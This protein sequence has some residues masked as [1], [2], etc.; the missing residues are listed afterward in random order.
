MPKNDIYQLKVTLRNSKPPIWRRI[1]VPGNIG[2]DKLHHILQ[3]TMGW[4]NSHLHQYIVGQTYYGQP[5]PEYGYDLEM[6][7]ER[8]V[9]LNQIAPSEKSRFIYEYDFGDGWEHLIV[10]EKILPP[11]KG[12][13]YPRCIKGKR[14]CPPEDVGGMWGYESFL[15]AIKDPNHPEHEDM[16]DWW[17]DDF[18]PEAFDLEEIN[19]ALQQFQ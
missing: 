16:L 10:V 4:W 9:K 17:G 11:E 3:A 6:E 1:E 13:R 7:D 2:L 12:V 19:D 5:D 14:A 15:E 18:D 8:K